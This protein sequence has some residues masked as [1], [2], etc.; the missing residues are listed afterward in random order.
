M[1]IRDCSSDLCSS[2]LLACEKRWPLAGFPDQRGREAQLAGFAKREDLRYFSEALCGMEY[3]HLPALAPTKDMF[4]AYKIKGGDWDIYARKAGEDPRR[5]HSN[6]T[7][8]VQINVCRLF[9]NSSL[10]PS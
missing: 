5:A 9:S 2:D 6:G 3:E 4:E 1:L 10:F 8:N 7:A